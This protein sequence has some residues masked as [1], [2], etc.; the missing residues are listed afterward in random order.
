MPFPGALYITYAY[1]ASVLIL[2]HAPFFRL[3]SSW[4]NFLTGGKNLSLPAKRGR[5][6]VH[7][8]MGKGCGRH[9][10]F[11]SQC[12]PIGFDFSSF[13]SSDDVG[14]SF[15]RWLHS[16]KACCQHL[17]P[18][19]FPYRGDQINGRVCLCPIHNPLE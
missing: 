7:F 2:E 14:S 4:E 17:V 5:T 9:A 12:V 16:N 6:A 10:A 1:T 18:V 11:S 15:D 8:C 13:H 3:E 19:A